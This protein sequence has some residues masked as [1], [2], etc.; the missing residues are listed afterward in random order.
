MKLPRWMRVAMLATAVMNIGGTVALTPVGA[1]VRI[2]L[3]LP[4][5]GHP[6]FVATVAAFIL[7]FGVAYAWAGATGWADPL[8]VTVAA[9]GK[10]TFFGLLVGF[11]VAGELPGTA[12]VAGVGDL[13][14]GL[15]FAAWLAR[16]WRLHRQGSRALESHT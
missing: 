9:A 5:G 11:W 16:A 1:P 6:L 7:I 4:D 2:A 8:F 13:V 14:F 10:L 12:P 15:L 3:G